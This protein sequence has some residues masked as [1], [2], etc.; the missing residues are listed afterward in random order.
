MVCS[1]PSQLTALATDR[2]CAGL[3]YNCT[4]VPYAQNHYNIRFWYVR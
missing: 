4:Y 3:L 2:H 1:T